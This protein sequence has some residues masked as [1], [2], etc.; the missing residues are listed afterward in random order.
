MR[1]NHMATPTQINEKRD[2]KSTTRKLLAYLAPYR[3]P[4]LAVIFFSILGSA[5]NIVG[6]MILGQAIT[7]VSNG[8]LAKLMGTGFIDF[9]TLLR[10][11]LILVT[12]YILSSLFML[13]QGFIVAEVAQKVSFKMREQISEK[14]HRMPVAF[15]DKVSFGDVLSVVTNDVD[16]ISQTLNQ[17]LSQIVSSLATLIGIIVMM[18]LINVQLTIIGLLIMP[19]SM[20]AASFIIKASQKHFKRQQAELGKV[21]GQVEELFGGHHILSAFNGEADAKEEFNESNEA[22]Y[23]TAHTSQFLSGILMPLTFFIGNLGY[24]A[25]TIYGA[26]LAARA[27][28]N[29]G[30]IMAFVQYIRS[31]NQPIQSIAQVGNVFQS[32]LAATERVFRFI[33]E[34]EEE[35]DSA[36]AIRNHESGT[37]LHMKGEVCFDH[38][39]F[40]YDP[41]QIIIKDF[42]LCVDPGQRVAIVGPT[43]AGKTTLVKLLM[44]FYDVNG[45]KITIDGIDIKDMMRSDLRTQCAMVLQDTWLFRGTVMDNIRYGRLSATDEE[46]IEAAKAAKADHFIR[47]LPGGY[48]MVINEEADNISQGQKQLLTIARAM[49]ADP[50]ILILDEATSS[51][52]T[53]TER[54]IQ[55]AMSMMMQGRTSFVIAHRLSTIRTADIILVLNEGDVVESGNHEELMQRDGFYKK[56]YE[57]QFETV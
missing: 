19:A 39:R 10:I 53:R 52:D 36:V 54:A 55:E 45:G 26:V 4:F 9:G 32:T 44:R 2:T 49:L 48:Q 29:V 22:L 7:L 17:S 28:I 13:V 43:G 15:Y 57:S 14:I 21:N 34:D 1:H 5:F 6:P 16:T 12:L 18:F 27:V 40:G 31:F 41:E 11:I 8:F 3:I 51:V 24:V 38:V 35:P 46:V 50:S 25:V 42:S 23:D 30:D 47:T 37:T 56:L 20:L 33:E